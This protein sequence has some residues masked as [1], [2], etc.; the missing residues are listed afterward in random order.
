MRTRVL[1]LVALFLCAVGVQAASKRPFTIEDLYRI[2]NVA[3]PQISPDGRYIAFVVTEYQLHEG[4]SNSDIWLMASDG[5]GLR[6]LTHSEE[7][8]WH[9]RWSPDG[10]TLLF[11]STRKDGAQIWLLPVEGGEPRQLTRISTGVSDPVW[12]PDG[13]RIAFSSSVFPECGANDSCNK[14]IQEKMDKGPIQ[15]HLADELLYRH[16]DFWKDGKVVHT[17]LVDVQTGEVRDLTPGPFDAPAF[18]LEGGRGYAFSPDG[19]ELCFV[20]NHDRDQA[21]STNKDLWIVP[22][23]GGEAVNITADNPAYDADPLYSPDGRYIAYRMQKVPGYESDRFRLALYDRKTGQKRVLTEGFDNWVDDFRWSPD[24]R[25]IYFIG[26][27]RGHFPLYRV[28]IQSGKIALVLDD[29]TIDSFEIAPDGRWFAYVRRSVAEPREV[30]RATVLGTGR[31][32]LTEFNRS[33]QEE[34]D[35]R[36]A[37]EMWVKGAGGD[38]IHVFVVKPHG[39]DPSQK[40]PLILNIHGGPQSQWADAFRGDWQVYPGAGYIVAFPNPHGSTGYGQ[41]F[42]EAISGDWGGKVMEDILRVADAL[43]AL[44]WVDENRM[45][46]MGWSW[47]GYAVMWLEG[48]TDRF[49]CLAA[50][51]GV[52]DLRSM[53]GATEELWFPEWDMRGTPWTSDLYE[54]FSPSNFVPNFKTP[55][56]VITGEQDFRVPYTQSLQFFTALQRQGVPSRLIVFKNDGHWPNFVKSMPLYY[57]AHLDW[58]SRWLGGGG[59]P[60][61]V[62]A[63]VRNQAW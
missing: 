56:L 24:S 18:S 27:V 12:S 3:D 57:A 63:L 20:S 34:V 10:K 60:W 16:W 15:A 59:S 52:Y 28:D 48:H 21:L 14:A 26:E 5:T 8:D 36:P 33:I 51:M 7:A 6:R 41:K 50:M 13:Q 49:R 25:S 43:A 22:V 44:P 55:C 58:F 61:P 19:K 35:I 62:E 47:G 29:K 40:Y 38:S 11:L 2:K 30:Y 39:F 45:A 53:Y 23:E 9:P 1:N 37:E 17:F 32:R 4:K 42:T 46:A 54:K 31:K